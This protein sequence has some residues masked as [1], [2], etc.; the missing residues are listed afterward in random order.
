M[1]KHDNPIRNFAIAKNRDSK[2]GSEPLSD[3]F[4]F[5]FCTKGKNG[6]KLYDLGDIV[7]DPD[8]YKFIIV[9]NLSQEGPL[10][11]DGRPTD[12]YAIQYLKNK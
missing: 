5:L 11:Q 7:F 1:N 3:E 4:S 2:R 6:E 9:E 12:G 8:G 10:D